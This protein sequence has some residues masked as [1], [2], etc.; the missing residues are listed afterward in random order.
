MF[1]R[2]SSR[3]PCPSASVAHAEDERLLV[4][5]HLGQLH[6][7]RVIS[8]GHVRFE[9]ICAGRMHLESGRT[10]NVQWDEVVNASE[11]G[12]DFGAGHLPALY[13]SREPLGDTWRL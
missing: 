6:D 10:S 7:C 5:S 8:G 1:N 2:T 11:A 9:R 12:F 4:R 3:S 13:M